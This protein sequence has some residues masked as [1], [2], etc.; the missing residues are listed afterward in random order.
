VNGLAREY[1][2]NNKHDIYVKIETDMKKITVV[3][4]FCRKNIVFEGLDYDLLQVAQASVSER[5]KCGMPLPMR[6]AIVEDIY[7]Q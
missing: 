6:D 5:C 2:F 7:H 1:L 4:S 3:C